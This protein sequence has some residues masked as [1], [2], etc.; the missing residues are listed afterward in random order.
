MITSV[1]YVSGSISI[2]IGSCIT[3]PRNKINRAAVC[4]VSWCMVVHHM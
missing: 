2:G 4:G 1:W 3:V